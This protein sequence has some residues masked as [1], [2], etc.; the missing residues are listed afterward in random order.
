MSAEYVKSDISPMA[1]REMIASEGIGERRIY[2]GN[3]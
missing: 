3:V 1:L 2:E